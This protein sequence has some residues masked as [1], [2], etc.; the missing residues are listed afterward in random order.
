METEVYES[1]KAQEAR[2]K[3]TQQVN[4]SSSTHFRQYVIH[5]LFPLLLLC[6]DTDRDQRMVYKAY[7]VVFRQEH[8][9]TY[10]I[11]FSA[12]L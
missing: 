6:F 2:Q 7:A 11:L 1:E 9:D 4:T 8:M 10:V 3:C 12:S 5:I